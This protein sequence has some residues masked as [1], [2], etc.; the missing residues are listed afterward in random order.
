MKSSIYRALAFYTLAVLSLIIPCFVSSNAY[1]VSGLLVLISIGMLYLIW[2]ANI[3]KVYAVAFV[4]G[5]LSEILAI[6][7]K[8]WSYAA[9]SFFG[10]PLWLPFLWGTAALFFL[11][12]Y[13]CFQL[14]RSASKCA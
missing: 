4:F 8:L 10:I 2:D 12:T 7:Q 3:L 14:T 9:P 13:K 6:H 1:V 11:G 5:P